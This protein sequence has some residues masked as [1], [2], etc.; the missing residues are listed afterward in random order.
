MKFVQIGAKPGASPGTGNPITPPSGSPPSAYDQLLAER[1]RE[2]ER[3]A[4][5]SDPENRHP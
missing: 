1:Q 5:S 3:A 2:F 4:R